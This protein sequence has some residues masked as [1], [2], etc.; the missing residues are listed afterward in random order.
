MLFDVSDYMKTHSCRTIKIKQLIKQFDRKVLSHKTD[1]NSKVSHLCILIGKIIVALK[2]LIL[3]REVRC[4][5]L[6]DLFSSYG[7][8]RSQLSRNCLVLETNIQEQ[9]IA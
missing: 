5:F 2:N 3:F 4:C 9:E 7:F 8:I 1:G 6:P